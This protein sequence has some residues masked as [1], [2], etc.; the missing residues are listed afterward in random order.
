MYVH[1]DTADIS[2]VTTITGFQDDYRRMQ[3]GVK[4]EF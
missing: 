3:L 2:S 1:S 4:F